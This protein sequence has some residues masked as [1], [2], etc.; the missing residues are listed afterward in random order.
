M[1]SSLSG[2]GMAGG[3]AIMPVT[4]PMI[5]HITMVPT[6]VWMDKY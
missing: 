3:K 2:A 6:V 5:E 4:Q 1:I